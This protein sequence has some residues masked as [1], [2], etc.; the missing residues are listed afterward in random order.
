MDVMCLSCWRAKA[1]PLESSD[2]SLF[3]IF[4][5]GI[6]AYN[7]RFCCINAGQ[8]RCGLCALCIRA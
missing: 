5:D 7:I 8:K 6:K 1:R 2:S 4:E 3:L